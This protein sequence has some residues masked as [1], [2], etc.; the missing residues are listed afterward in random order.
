MKG[1]VKEEIRLGII[2]TVASYLIPQLFGEWKMS[3]DQLKLTIHELKLVETARFCAKS[4]NL[5][6]E[7][8]RSSL[9]LFLCEEKDSFLLLS[10]F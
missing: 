4:I 2:P 6:C 5:V 9:S 7:T 8:V 1:K 10:I 3:F